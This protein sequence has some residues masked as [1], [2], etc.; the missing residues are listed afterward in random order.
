LAVSL[1]ARGSI[2]GPQ[3]TL[4]GLVLTP[5]LRTTYVTVGVALRTTLRNRIDTD[6]VLID[7]RQ[8]AISAVGMGRWRLS[9]RLE[10]ELGANAGITFYERTSQS[11]DPA[12]P[13]WQLTNKNHTSLSAHLGL[14]GELRWTFT[15]S[16][17]L[18]V[19][20]GIEIPLRPVSFDF[21]YATGPDST[22]RSKLSHLNGLEPWVALS[23]S[24]D[25]FSF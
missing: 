23:L 17:G 12:D 25:V 10:L 19:L 1:A 18:S 2:A 16:L 15:H 6:P 24:A 22:E 13:E 4:L 21:S 14:L 20:C 9:S 11:R 7:L 5:Q 8:H 3:S